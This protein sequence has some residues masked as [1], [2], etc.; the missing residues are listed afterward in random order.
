MHLPMR[1]ELDLRQGLHMQIFHFAGFQHRFTL[2]QLNHIMA[3]PQGPVMHAMAPF[4]MDIAKALH[5][6]QSR[7]RRE[8]GF[9]AIG[10]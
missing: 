5:I 2:G 6:K 1:L 7:Q 3:D 4:G 9:H 8:H 10:L